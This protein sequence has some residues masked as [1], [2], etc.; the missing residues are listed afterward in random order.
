MKIEF[1]PHTSSICYSSLSQNK[2]KLNASS[3]NKRLKLGNFNSDGQSLVSFKEESNPKVNVPIRVIVRKSSGMNSNDTIKKILETKANII[4]FEDKLKNLEIN[5]P[6]QCSKDIPKPRKISEAEEKVKK[7]DY[8]ESVWEDKFAEA[9]R[10]AENVTKEKRYENLKNRLISFFSSSFSEKIYQQELNEHYYSFRDQYYDPNIAVDRA[11][12]DTWNNTNN[13]YKK[14]FAECANEKLRD[15]Y[16]QQIAEAKKQLAKLEK[17][18]A[19]CVPDQSL[20]IKLNL[21]NS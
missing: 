8:W 1:R 4:A 7:H 14:Y 10:I 3:D 13:A 12:V 17:Q 21:K 18:V 6:I 20:P 2:Q 19:L 16:Q 5:N 9:K 15:Q 11:A